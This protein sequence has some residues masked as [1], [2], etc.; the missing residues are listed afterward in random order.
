MKMVSQCLLLL[1]YRL[2]ALTG[3]CIHQIVVL[4]QQASI[5]FISKWTH[6]LISHISFVDSIG[7]KTHSGS[8]VSGILTYCIPLIISSF[9]HSKNYLVNPGL[10]LSDRSSDSW[11]E[12]S[13]KPSR[14]FRWNGPAAERHP[15]PVSWWI[16]PGWACEHLS[17]WRSW[18]P[19]HTRWLLRQVNKAMFYL[20]YDVTQRVTDIRGRSMFYGLYMTSH[21][22]YYVWKTLQASSSWLIKLCVD[23]AQE[24]EHFSP[25]KSR[26]PQYSAAAI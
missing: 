10:S 5:V 16:I 26:P 17:L 6:S 2:E 8:L 3:P 25:I 19:V 15:L 18:R 14:L 20:P 12:A 1:V 23:V 11:A 21:G 9:S 22:L 4:K 13:P 7:V 24:P